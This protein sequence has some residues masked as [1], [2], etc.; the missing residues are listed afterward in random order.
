V[1][2]DACLIP[3]DCPTYEKWRQ[4]CYSQLRA[5]GMSRASGVVFHDLRRTYAC[6]RMDYLVRERKMLPERAAQLVARE[7][8]HG[9][10]EVLRWYIADRGTSS[11]A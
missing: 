7:L 1:T 4:K 2:G 8:G 5:A 9:R 10:T 6:E 11:V 3:R